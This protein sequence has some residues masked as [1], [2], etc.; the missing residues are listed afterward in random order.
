MSITWSIVLRVAGDHDVQREASKQHA[1][2]LQLSI[3]LEQLDVRS[4]K[5]ASELHISREM[6]KVHANTR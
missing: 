5:L 4:E 6:D 1:V 2:D 3:L